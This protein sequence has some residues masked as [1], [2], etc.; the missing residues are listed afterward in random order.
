MKRDEYGIIIQANGT[1]VN[2]QLVDDGGDSAFSTGINAFCGSEKDFQLMPL[3]IKNG[4][5]VRHPYQTINTGT[6]PHNDPLA[7]SADQ[8]KGFFAGLH[9][10]A[11]EPSHSEVKQACLNYAR[12][13]RVNKD[14]L[15]PANKLYLYKCADTK[16]PLWLSLL[17]YPNFTGELL[18]NTKINPGHEQTQFPVMCCMYGAAWISLLREHHPDLFKNITE[19]FCTWRQRCE[20]AS[21]LKAKILKTIGHKG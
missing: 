15:S 13:W 4:K 7:T 19:Y 12:G 17:A 20:I 8:V 5:L 6:A 9:G 11:N 2:G 18:V 16:P 1:K 10:R 21:N 3:F 14:I